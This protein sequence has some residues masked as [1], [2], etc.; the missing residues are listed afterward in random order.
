VAGCWVD[1]KILLEH[2]QAFAMYQF[3]TIKMFTGNDEKE[4]K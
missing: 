1:K 3:A 4:H 2:S